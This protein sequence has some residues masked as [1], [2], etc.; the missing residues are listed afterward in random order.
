VSFLAVSAHA[1]VQDARRISGR[2]PGPLGA[3]YENEIDAAML[4]HMASRLFEIY[5]GYS[6]R[7]VFWNFWH[8]SAAPVH[9]T[10]AHFGAAIEFLQKAYFKNTQSA[11]KSIV[12]DGQVWKELRLRLEL[13]IKE[14]RLTD[15]EKRMFTNKAQ[16]LNT[17]PQSVL[18]DRLFDA[19]GLEISPLEKDVWS[20]RNRAA[21]GSSVGED[22][23]IQTIRENKI[24]MMLMTRIVLVISG[25]N[26]H[27]YDYYTLGRPTR[28]VSEQ[29]P[30]DRESRS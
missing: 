24:L 11:A 15:D 14:A 29:V 30:D 1:L 16:N 9:M 4:S 18:S 20:N 8:A 5:E 2:P 17:A 21:H 12:A 6:L 7:T 23:A 10:A 26:N 13:C 3:R 28:R 25:S 19:L 22:R 27:Y